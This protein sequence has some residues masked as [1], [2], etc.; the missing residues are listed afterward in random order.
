MSKKYIYPVEEL[1]NIIEQMAKGIMPMMDDTMQ[2]EVELRFKELQNTLFDEDDDELDPTVQRKHREILDKHLKEN[3]RKASRDDVIIMKISDEQKAEIR[4][5][6]SVS[7][8]RPNPYST[9]N[10]RDDVLYND[11]ERRAIYQRLAGLKNCYYNQTDYVN[12]IA[13]IKDAIEYSLANDYP[14][15]TKEEAIKEFNAGRIKFNYCNIPKLYINHSTQ[16]TDPE[17]LKGIV[18]GDITLKDKRDDDDNIRRN[19][20]KNYKPVA[21]DYTITSDEQYRQMIIAHKNGYDT[22]MSTAI[23]QKATVYNRL[24]IPATNRFAKQPIGNNGLPIL[25]DWTQEGSGES[26]Y[27]MING[28]KTQTS[29]IVHFLNK[30]NGDMLNNVVVH[31][32]NDFLRSMK[33]NSQQTGGYDY[34]PNNPAPGLQYNAE[35][36]KIEQDLLATIRTV[37][38]VK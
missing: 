8:V 6:M 35:A 28:K 32:M 14:W 1:D 27:N 2:M 18:T 5:N 21:V 13:I 7:I 33:Y 23:R 9:Y 11:S 26:Y 15:L 37:G 22:P 3:K 24:A 12:A 38:V 19:R 34:V 30:E 29:D 25:V 16:I 17:I 20:N 10:K 4:K 36:A 31:N